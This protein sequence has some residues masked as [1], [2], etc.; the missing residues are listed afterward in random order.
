MKGTKEGA[1]MAD[2]M[3]GILSADEWNRRQMG[4]ICIKRADSEMY[5]LIEKA[6]PYLPRELI[7]ALS[8]GIGD[9]ASAYSNAG[10]LYGVYVAFEI[11][12]TAQNPKILQREYISREGERADE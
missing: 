11:Q 4:D 9:V 6:E 12:K 2:I 3:N 10:I 7:N 5:N 1:F 8:D